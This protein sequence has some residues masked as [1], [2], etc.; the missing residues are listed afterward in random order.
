MNFT[1][2]GQAP[3]HFERR[4]DD[5]ALRELWDLWA[6]ADGFTAWWGPDQFRVE[7]QAFELRAGGALS[8]EM[9]AATPESIAAMQRMNMP[10]SHATHGRFVE[11]RPFEYLEI[12]HRIDFIPGVEPY[13]NRIRVW[14]TQDGATAVMRIDIDPHHDAAFTGMAQKGMSSQLDKVPGALRARR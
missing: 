8:Y 10:A 5:T 12:A 13:E 2:A 7:V 11:V 6:T 1:A 3:I 4:Y 9:I 14:F